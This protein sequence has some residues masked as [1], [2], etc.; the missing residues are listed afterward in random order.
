MHNIVLAHRI[1][2]SLFLLQY[3]IKLVL[4]LTNKKEQ[5][6]NYTKVTRIPEMLVSVGFLVTGGWLIYQMPEIGKFM[7]IKLVAVFAAI[8]LA[9]VGFKKGN[10]ALAALSIVL[11]FG[12]YGLAEMNT[13]AMAGGKVDTS[14]AKDPLEAGKIVYQNKNCLMCHGADGKAGVNGAKDLSVTTLSLDEQKAIIKNGK[15]PM[16]GYNDLT[17]EQMNDLLQYIG[18]LRKN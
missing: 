6:A 13:K 2:V 3:V 9:I 1:L 10:K 17:D 4:L 14:S 11:L 5:L 18:S 8:P 12:A 15:T 16:P 7:I